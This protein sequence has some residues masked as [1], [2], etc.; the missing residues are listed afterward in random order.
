MTYKS[1]AALEMA[2]KAAAAASPLDTNRAIAS[3]YFHRLLCR[4]FAGGN[5]AFVLK[6]G[7]SMLSRTVGAR[8]TRDIDL[9]A[10]QD[11]LDRAL[12][13]L[14]ELAETD[15]GDFVTFE[16]AGSRSI[17][18]EDEYR[19]GLSVRFVPIIGS[20]RMQR[21]SID[22]VADEVPLERAELVAPADRIEIE[23][24]Q[25]CDYLVYPVENALADK[26]CALVERHG[27][28]ASSRVKDLVDIAVYATTCPVDGGELQKCVHREAAVRRIALAGVLRRAR[29]LGRI[30]RQAVREAV[31][32]NGAPGVAE[33]DRRGSRPRGPSA[34]PRN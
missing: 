18:V 5:D 8:A 19:D 28:R 24:L 20:K 22:L 7:Q 30:Q 13:K 12:E 15:M 1:A 34:R 14:K 6:G 16:F 33:N 25:V 32:K 2:V 4:V 23:G 31:R 17:K 27:G 3:F 9:L 10:K 21:I 26:L 11:D 29:R